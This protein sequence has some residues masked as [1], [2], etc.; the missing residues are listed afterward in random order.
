[1]VMIFVLVT[2]SE[3]Q[4]VFASLSNIF[5]T[6]KTP[7]QSPASLV[8]VASSLSPYQSFSSPEHDS[9]SVQVPTA[10]K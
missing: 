9:L 4:Y 8:T 5:G 1:M 2:A 6:G 10:E 3:C 7:L